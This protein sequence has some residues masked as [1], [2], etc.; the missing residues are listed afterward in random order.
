MSESSHSVF[1][2]SLTA[3]ARVHE[4][5]VLTKPC[6]IVS[7]PPP[8]PTGAPSLLAPTPSPASD[9]RSVHRIS[10]YTD[11]CV[12]WCQPC[13]RNERV[14]LTVSNR[15]TNSATTLPPP[16]STSPATTSSAP[17]ALV[18][19]KGQIRPLPGFR[20]DCFVYTV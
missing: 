12:R 19:S 5:C 7:R 17:Y 10:E 14:D 3:V 2:P 6:S 13:A 15:Y 18:A 20:N 16:P 4:M 11:Y 9:D 1:I 8:P